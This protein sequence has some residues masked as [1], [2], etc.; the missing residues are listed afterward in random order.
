MIGIRSGGVFSGEVDIEDIKKRISKIIIDMEKS[1]YHIGID[2]DPSHCMSKELIARK[3]SY[4]VFAG[5]FN[6]WTFKEAS[7]FIKRLSKE[8]GT[9]IMHMCW[10][11]MNDFV[12][13]QIW[14]DG[15]PLFEVCENPIGRIVRRVT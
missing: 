10:D 7:E 6:N 5:V 12:Q 8:F 13:C 4:V 3:G 11:E 9:E 2:K 1:K 15:K 14:L